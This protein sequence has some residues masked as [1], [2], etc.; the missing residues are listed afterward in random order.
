MTPNKN[1]VV[2]DRQTTIQNQR[3]TRLRARITR[4]TP[5]S[6]GKLFPETVQDS[7]TSKMT[8]DVVVDASTSWNLS[9]VRTDSSAKNNLFSS[10]QRLLEI[11]RRARC[12]PMVGTPGSEVLT[13]NSSTKPTYFERSVELELTARHQ[14]QHK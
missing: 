1:M 2:H 10:M 6:V 7:A 9:L 12:V 4:G 5:G 14:Q 3:A 8:G 13:A 11:P